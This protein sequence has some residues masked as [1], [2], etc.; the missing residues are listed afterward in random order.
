MIPD[1]FHH[2]MPHQVW[3]GDRP[4]SAMLVS[5]AA[6]REYVVTHDLGHVDGRWLVR[7]PGVTI[8]SQREI[9][10][11]GKEGWEA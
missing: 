8:R 10:R 9:D 6:A 4:E 5:Y 11:D 1:Y 2:V 3:V 7:K